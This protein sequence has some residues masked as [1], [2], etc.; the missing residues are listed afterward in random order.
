MGAQ[1]VL[2]P[3]LRFARDLVDPDTGLAW[4]LDPQSVD[5]EARMPR[6]PLARDVAIAIRDFLW[7]GDPGA[8]A[9]APRVVTASELAPL[10]RPVRFADV[11]RLFGRSCIHCHAHTTGDQASFVF[12]FARSALDLSS[13]E[14]VMAGVVLPDGTR[15]SVVTPDPTGTA[16]LLSR[17][18]ARHVENA[19]ELAPARA[20]APTAPVGMPLGLPPLSREDLRVVATWLAQGAPR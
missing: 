10:G 16:P 17:L 11:R 14:G 15:R 5:R 20:A 9:R 4:I 13:Y 1:S 8:P 7:L 3:D 12:G 18:L 2:G 6:T 19:H